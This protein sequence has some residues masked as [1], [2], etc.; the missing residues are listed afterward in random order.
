MLEHWRVNFGEGLLDV[1][2]SFE[3]PWAAPVRCTG[4][5]NAVEGQE[6][7]KTSLPDGEGWEWKND[8]EL[9][10][11]IRI[12]SERKMRRLAGLKMV[13]FEG[14]RGRLAGLAMLKVFEEGLAPLG[15]KCASGRSCKGP[16]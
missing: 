2:L 8:G 4:D 12:P 3:L 9:L 16:G 14:E 1:R 10:P 13:D 15:K 11:G 5:V 7:P 6:A